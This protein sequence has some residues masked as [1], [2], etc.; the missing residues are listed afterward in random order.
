MEVI[1]IIGIYKITN[2]INNKSYI[3]QLANIERRFKE[4]CYKDYHSRII[5]DIAIKKYGKEMD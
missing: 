5:L 3:G 4:H 2:I 1:Y